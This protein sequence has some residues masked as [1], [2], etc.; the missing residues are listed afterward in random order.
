MNERLHRGLLCLER[1]EVL[2]LHD[3]RGLLKLVHVRGGV[4]HPLECVDEIRDDDLGLLDLR[5]G[6]GEA[7]GHSRGSERWPDSDGRNG[8]DQNAEHFGI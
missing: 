4:E 7:P 6:G 1:L 2:D 8:L 5:G 3:D